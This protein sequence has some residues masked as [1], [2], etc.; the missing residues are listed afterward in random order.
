[1]NITI[2]ASGLAP[3]LAKLTAELNERR[4]RIAFERT[5]TKAIF[6]ARDF[7][8]HSEHITLAGDSIQYWNRSERIVS[9]ATACSVDAT[10]HASLGFRLSA[11]G[12][13]G[14]PDLNRSET[15]LEGLLC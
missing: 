9:L 13:A 3:T 4:E 1:M 7:A 8:E 12:E 2:H 15:I 5:G 6:F 11:I 10:I 14:G